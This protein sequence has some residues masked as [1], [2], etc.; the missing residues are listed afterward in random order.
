MKQ[1]CSHRVKCKG[2]GD[3]GAAGQ[4]PRCPSGSGA[5]QGQHSALSVFKCQ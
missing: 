5:V 4:V 1:K 3:T 2:A